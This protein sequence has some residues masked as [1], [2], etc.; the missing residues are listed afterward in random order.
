MDV[1]ITSTTAVM[2]LG[3]VDLGNDGHAILLEL[4]K[5]Y[6]GSIYPSS[7]YVFSD[8]VALTGQDAIVG[9]TK[10]ANGVNQPIVRNTRIFLT[11]VAKTGNYGPRVI[12]YNRIHV[13][14][15]GTITVP[16]GTA[17]TIYEALP[18]INTNYGI[19]LSQ[20]DVVDAPLP[21]PDSNGY[22]TVTL[23]IKPTSVLFYGTVKVSLTD[24]QFSTGCQCADEIAAIEQRVVNCVNQVQTFAASLN[25]VNG[26]VSAN[27]DAIA[28]IQLQLSGIGG[29]VTSQIKTLADNLAAYIQSNDTALASYKQTTNA[30]IGTLVDEVGGLTQT[31]TTLQS[32]TSQTAIAAGNAASA[33]AAAQST[34]NAAATTASNALNTAT[35]AQ[36]TANTATTSAATAQQNAVSAQSTANQAVQTAN[37]ASTNAASASTAASTAYAAVQNLASSM[38]AMNAAVNQATTASTS[39][40]ALATAANTTATTALTTSNNAITLATSASNKA[41]AAQTTASAASTL[42]SSANALATQA[43]SEIASIPTAP[44]DSFYPYAVTYLQATSAGLNFTLPA[45]T[46]VFDSGTKN[47]DA[48]V[49][50]L[51]ANTAT[52]IWVT[53]AGV[54]SQESVA[55]GLESTLP[56]HSEAYFFAYRVKTNGTQIVSVERKGN[57]FKVPKR[58]TFDIL[59]YD[60]MADKYM[61]QM[62]TNTWPAV[63]EQV[64]EGQVYYT[65]TTLWRCVTGGA[66]DVPPADPA[67]TEIVDDTY[68][69][70]TSGGATFQYVTTAAIRGTPLTKPSGGVDPEKALL[71]SAIVEV[72]LRSYQR[73]NYT[74]G[75]EYGYSGGWYQIGAM[76]KY[77]FDAV[78]CMRVRATYS[79]GAN[80]ISA[81]GESIWKCTVAGTTDPSFVF[82]AA[83]ALD[84][85]VV[86]GTVTWTCIGVPNLTNPN[87]FNWF[88]TDKTGRYFVEP[89]SPVRVMALITIAARQVMYSTVNG[90]D[91]HLNS[92]VPNLTY[93]DLFKSMISNILIASVDQ[94]DLVNRY[95]TSSDYYENE[96]PQYLEDSAMVYDALFCIA[97]LLQIDQYPT[98][99]IL[100]YDRVLA[101]QCYNTYQNILTGIQTLWD[102]QNGLYRTNTG[103]ASMQ[104]SNGS[105]PFKDCVED[106]L[107][108][109]FYNVPIGHQRANALIKKTKELFPFWWKRNDIIGDD[110]YIP[111]LMLAYFNFFYDRTKSEKYAQDSVEM[112][113][114]EQFINGTQIP[115]NDLAC[116]LAIKAQQFVQVDQMQNGTDYNTSLGV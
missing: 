5:N 3:T 29:D 70:A 4:L 48:T 81:S 89:C 37:I 114:Y 7:D 84:A 66:V 86:D 83:P 32:T 51:S 99:G 101:T 107:K 26:F 88:K 41:T 65:A 56:V 22:V 109:I 12:Y 30:T 111:H 33:A 94:N 34:A 106:Q 82:P 17:T 110:K 19:G 87:M 59:D 74:D 98:G 24:Y 91:M 47:L 90:L 75:L 27:T 97:P 1:N 11:P 63:G 38:T 23:S 45:I 13:S 43:I 46:V 105:A 35:A 72:S 108:L 2:V 61:L 25:T 116:Y 77:L 73:D 96:H 52:D 100:P 28:A 71:A 9:V 60:T 39:A 40:T 67:F 16:I 36:A 58:P 102:Y 78:V 57:T 50:A 85:T 49:L 62:Y 20:D 115:V 55:V 80:V 15:L 95:V 18:Q 14:D 8:P 113:E 92:L 10:D 42:A 79:V 103:I 64:I 53:E 6:D 76:L 68:I 44:P 112:M 31:V 104:F 69:T 54:Y 21:A 93:Y